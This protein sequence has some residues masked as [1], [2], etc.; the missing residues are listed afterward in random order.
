[1]LSALRNFFISFLVCLLIFGFVSYKYIWPTIHDMVDF[2][3]ISQNE[4]NVSGGNTDNSIDNPINTTDGRTVTVAFVCKTSESKVCSVLL[5]RANEGT[6]RFTYCRIPLT[7]KVINSVG[8]GVPVDYYLENASL[9]ETKT[10]LASLVGFDIDHCVIVDQKAAKQLLTKLQDP[11]F[12]VSRTIKYVNPIYAGKEYPEGGEPEDYYITLSATRCTLDE[13]L[14]DAV[15]GNRITVSGASTISVAG[16]MCAS[17]FEQFM[18]NA[19]TKRNISNLSY[20]LNYVRTDITVNDIEANS[21]I[22]FT[23]DEYPTVTTV[24]YPS[25]WA[26][27]IKMFREADG[28]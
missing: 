9:T 13:A 28:R 14:L 19:G 16:D 26:T 27:A 24:N 4:S 20:L 23:Y 18:K 1:M 17:L 21:D 2:N 5:A 8:V 11:Y 25:D 15:L 10:K 6:Q 12:D 3:D 22:F 7:T